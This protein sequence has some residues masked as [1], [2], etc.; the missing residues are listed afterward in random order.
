[1][2]GIQ[3]FSK[4][5]ILIILFLLS[6][7]FVFA[8]IAPNPVETPAGLLFIGAIIVAVLGLIAWV[9]IRMIKKRRKS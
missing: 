4:I 5:S 1:M 3:Y 7:T 6:G 2:K 9:I 8:D